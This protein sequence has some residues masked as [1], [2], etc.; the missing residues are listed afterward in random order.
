MRLQ[1]RVLISNDSSS[2]LLELVKHSEHSIILQL[3]NLFSR[4]IKETND[5]NL[6]IF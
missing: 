4:K 6:Y 3:Y 5:S 2:S 1:N